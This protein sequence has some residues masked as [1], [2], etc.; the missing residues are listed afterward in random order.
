MRKSNKPIPKWRQ[1]FPIEWDKDNYV[2]RREFTKF[3]VLVSGAMCVGNGAVVALDKVR[4]GET[5]PET[6]IAGVSEL[7]A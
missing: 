4:R 6:D 3:L 5:F 1:D 7:P 2:T